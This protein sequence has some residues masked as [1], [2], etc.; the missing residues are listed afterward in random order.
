MPNGL[1]GVEIFHWISENVDQLVVWDKKQGITKM[2]PLG[3][4]NQS[5]CV[6]TVRSLTKY[7]HVVNL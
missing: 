5:C 7:S 3:T 1:V 4:M 6:H 2:N